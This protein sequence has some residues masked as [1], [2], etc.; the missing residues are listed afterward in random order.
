MGSNLAPT[1]SAVTSS[2]TGSRMPLTRQRSQGIVPRRSTAEGL[3]DPANISAL[4]LP[5]PL[6]RIP[7]E[8]QKQADRTDALWAQM[9]STLEEVELTAVNGA[10]VFGPEH[11]KALEGLR[12]AQ[13]ALAQ[14]WARSEADDAVESIDKD[15]KAFRG[16]GIGSEGKSALDDTEAGRSARNSASGRPAS[17]AG[18]AANVDLK[19]EEETEADIRL[20]RRR[21]EANDQYFQRV[22][23]GVLDVVEKLENVAVAMKAVENES[24]DTW[25]ESES[26]VS[27][28]AS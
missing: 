16:S 1:I 4:P 10:H 22:N 11:T 15:A 17:S 5:R 23:G 28:D 25:E 3:I 2:S 26:P 14:A 19:L 9:Q 6:A 27:N 21:R 20:A 18:V 8:G 13:I 7:S 24:K 12:M